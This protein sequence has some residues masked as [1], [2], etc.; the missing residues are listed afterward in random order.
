[1]I[2]KVFSSKQMRRI[3][4][5]YLYTLIELLI[6]EIYLYFYLKLLFNEFKYHC[7][8][9]KYKRNKQHVK[10]QS[11]SSLSLVWSVASP[12]KLAQLGH[13]Q[14][15]QTTENSNPCFRAVHLSLSHP[16]LHLQR[17][18]CKRLSVA[19]GRLIICG[20]SVVVS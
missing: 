15:P 11:S 4:V 16:L 14:C 7:K 6:F 3:R 8:Y 19:A 10:V 20:V 9:I 17:I 18:I 2:K 13:L 5:L 1:M 12:D